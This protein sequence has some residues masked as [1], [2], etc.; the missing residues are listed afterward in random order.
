M[1][2]GTQTKWK[3]RGVELL[4]TSQLYDTHQRNGGGRIKKSVTD[5]V[6][7]K[8]FNITCDLAHG[9]HTDWTPATKSDIDVIKSILNPNKSSDDTYWS[10]T[11]NWSWAADQHD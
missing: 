3:S 9:Y 8:I 10:N 2:N 7:G 5:L 11:A 4:T 6:T 1:F